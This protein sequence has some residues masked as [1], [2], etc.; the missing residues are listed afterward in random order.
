MVSYQNNRANLAEPRGIDLHLP[1][2]LQGKIKVR[3]GQA[4]AGGTHSCRI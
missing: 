1:L 4:L 3:L 2:L